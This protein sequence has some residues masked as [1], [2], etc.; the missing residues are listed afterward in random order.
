MKFLSC[1]QIMYNVSVESNITNTI[2]YDVK[3][4]ENILW[5]QIVGPY[6][7]YTFSFLFFFLI[8]NYGIDHWPF[9]L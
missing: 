6:S 3:Q 4:W 8:Q 5:I 9:V 7:N 1:E 2:M